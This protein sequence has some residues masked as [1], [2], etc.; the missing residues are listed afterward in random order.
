MTPEE[1]KE[2]M[3]KITKEYELDEEVGH[4][5]MDRLICEVLNE[6]G[7]HEGIKI[8]EEFPKWYA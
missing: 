4:I 1:F 5:K 8:F 3:A 7:Y 2:K 6:L